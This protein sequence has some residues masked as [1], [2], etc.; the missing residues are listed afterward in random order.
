MRTTLVIAS[1]ALAGSAFAASD[2]RVYLAYG[3]SSFAAL[4]GSSVGSEMKPLSAVPAIGSKFTVS[5][6]VQ[7][8]V[9]TDKRYGAC[10][11]FLGFD[12]ATTNNSTSGYAS[13]S[14]GLAAGISKQ[15]SIDSDFSNWAKGLPGV[16]N[17][18]NPLSVDVKTLA[19]AKIR[20]EALG[21]TLPSLRSIGI[22]HSFGFEPGRNLFLAA[23]AKHRLMDLVV[24]NLAIG[25]SQYGDAT[26]ENGLTL[27]A[28][29]KVV[30]S[31]ANLFGSTM[32]TQMESTVKYRLGP[33]PEPPVWLALAGGL[34]LL[35]RRRRS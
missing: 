5:I 9:Q 17:T 26:L 31:G 3:D 32:A 14:D 22:N 7:S 8:T 24:T 1:V 10:N 13:W 11:L 23:G 12:M 33:V 15:I 27:N 20:G 28:S 2:L 6:F 21:G 18:W 19:S 29:P 34:A 35:R 30:S 25:N 4:N 16:D